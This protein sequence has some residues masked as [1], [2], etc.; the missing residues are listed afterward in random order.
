MSIDLPLITST[1]L[2]EWIPYS[3]IAVLAKEPIQLLSK[4]EQTLHIYH[5]LQLCPKACLQ[6]L[7]R[8]DQTCPLQA[9]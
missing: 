3:G 2:F 8:Q 4:H 7:S 9:R 6:R 5:S 1:Q